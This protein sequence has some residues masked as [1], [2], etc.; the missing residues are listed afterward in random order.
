MSLITELTA[1][2]PPPRLKTR[3]IDRHAW[4]VDAGFYTLIP[5]AVV[6]PENENE[7]RALFQLASKHNT[8]I[9]FRTAGTSLKQTK[10]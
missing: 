1:L 8:S 3:P 6:F 5:K 4:S 9:T 2:F 10:A 7:I